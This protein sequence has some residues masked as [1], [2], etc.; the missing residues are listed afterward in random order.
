M[1][2][3]AGLP[4]KLSCDLVMRALG[5]RL[6]ARDI[7]GRLDGSG[8]SI[9]QCSTGVF[10]KL[11][12]E[13]LPPVPDAPRLQFGMPYMG[14]DSE[15]YRVMWP[16]EVPSGGSKLPSSSFTLAPNHTIETLLWLHGFL[17]DQGVPFVKLANK[18]G[19][20]FRDIRWFGP[21]LSDSP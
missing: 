15:R 9:I 5:S 16:G 7:P 1:A 11:K 4:L 6:I 13:N 12:L 18:S 3:L 21:Q 20:G 10:E 14:A 19:N 2:Y 17:V 8:H